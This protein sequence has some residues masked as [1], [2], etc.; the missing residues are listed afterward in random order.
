M[1]IPSR[2]DLPRAPGEVAIGT[3]RLEICHFTIFRDPLR[4]KEAEYNGENDILEH[5]A[6]YGWP[7]LVLL[8]I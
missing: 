7:A 8:G 2:L 6:R 3:R 5:K 1:G 4:A